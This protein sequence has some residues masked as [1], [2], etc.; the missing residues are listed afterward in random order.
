VKPWTVE[1]TKDVAGGSTAAVAYDV[2]A[3][4]NTCRP[5]ANPCAGC[6]LGTGCPY[7]GANHTE[8]NYQVSSLLIAYQ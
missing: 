2:E 3:Y 5:D 7:D 8:P 4:D 1:V 6:S